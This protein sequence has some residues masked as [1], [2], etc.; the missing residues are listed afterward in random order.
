M[1]EA[2]RR[3][4]DATLPLWLKFEFNTL[5]F[6]PHWHAYCDSYKPEAEHIISIP[7]SDFFFLLLAHNE[8]GLPV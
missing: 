5:T 3:S 7:C 2:D 1:K 6:N 4:C 8:G